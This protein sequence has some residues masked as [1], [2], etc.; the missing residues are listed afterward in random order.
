MP[1]RKILVLGHAR[2]GKDTVAE[3]I[4]NY[5]GESYRGSSEI[6]AEF[7]FDYMKDVFGYNSVECCFKDRSNH[8]AEWH[9]ILKEY[10][11]DDK[12]ALGKLIYRTNLVYCGVRDTEELR[13]IK[14]E[15]NPLVIWVC[16]KQRGVALEPVDSMNIELTGSMIVIEN[17]SSVADLKTAVALIMQAYE[18]KN[19]WNTRFT[20]LAE[21]IASWSKDNKCRV[22]AILVSP[23]KRQFYT[24]Y[25]GMPR[26]IED[27]EY[28]KNE[29]SVHAELNALFNAST[30]TRGWTMFVTKPPCLT[31]VLSLI[32]AGIKEVYCPRLVQTSSWYKDQEKALNMLRS[33]NINVHFTD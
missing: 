9:N 14:K 13:A 10:N 17:D 12:A 3:L 28:A 31:C 7:V 2:H 16:S 8:R 21:Q 30:D 26:G 19:K 29:V 20:A 25:N 24:G 22:G 32:Q 1:V 23:D 11:K 18:Y 33:V 6:C 5:T 4:A 27:T 15:F